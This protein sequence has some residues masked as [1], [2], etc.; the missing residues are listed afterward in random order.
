MTRFV[1]VTILTILTF[2]SVLKSTTIQ[3]PTDHPTIQAG[4][5]ASVD[6]DT[7]L[8]MP[9]TY[10]ENIDYSGH[11]VLVMSLMGSSV[12]TIEPAD[13][14]KST[15]KATN[16]EDLPAGL[17]GFTVR[18][19]G[20]ASTVYLQC[21]QFLVTENVFR[22]NIPG[23]VNPLTVIRGLGP[24]TITYNVFFNNQ[25]INTMF[26]S[27]TCQIINNTLDSNARGIYSTSFGTTIVNN[28]VTNCQEYTIIGAFA[29]LDFNDVWPAGTPTATGPHGFSA[30]PVY[31]DAGSHDYSLAFPSSCLG[32]G[33]LDPSYLDSLGRPRNLG[34]R[35]YQDTVVPPFAVRLN[36]GMIGFPHTIA[37]PPTISWGFYHYGY[38]QT[39]YELEV[40]T[41]SDWSVAEL[42]A[43]GPV[44]SGDTAIL[45][46]GADLSFGQTYYYRVR[47]QDASGWGPWVERVSVVNTPPPTPA[48]LFPLS[49]SP[50]NARGAIMA[51]QNVTDID[52]DSVTYEFAV[53]ED[54]LLSTLAAV[55]VEVPPDSPFTM[56]PPCSTLAFDRTYWWV[57]RAFDGYDTSIATAP[58]L[59]QTHS[60]PIKI[61]IPGAYQTIQ[62]AILNSA[63]EDTIELAPG[64]Y[65]EALY[66]DNK[67][68]V[69]RSSDGREVT[70]IQPA[71]SNRTAISV[72]GGSDGLPLI[73]GFTLLPLATG[74][75]ISGTGEATVEDCDIS[76]GNR[77][78]G[79]G[80]YFPSSGL[81][82]RNCD[83]HDNYASD[84]GGAIYIEGG[85]IENC[86]IY[87]NSA[88]RGPGIC[89]GGPITVKHNL[90]YGNSGAL[91]EGSAIYA[92]WDHNTTH[93][94]ITNNTIALNTRGITAN[95]LHA[96]DIS[97]NIIA[98]NDFAGVATHSGSATDC[99]KYNDLYNNG[100]GDTCL[101]W[102]GFSAD[103]QF[104]DTAARDFTL[105]QNSPCIDAGYVDS[106]ETDP[107]GTPPDLGAIPYEFGQPTATNLN[108]GSDFIDRV[109]SPNP[110]FYWSILD[111]LHRQQTS[112]EVEVGTSPSIEPF[113]VW[114]SGAVSTADTSL[115][116]GATGVAE[117]LQAGL[118]YY[119]RIRVDVGTGF[120]PWH[121]RV[122]RTNIPPGVPQPIRPTGITCV[123]LVELELICDTA[124]NPDRD[125]IWYEFQVFED[126]TA[127]SPLAS[128]TATY[129]SVTQNVHVAAPASLE[130][131][132]QY[133]WRVRA[134]D[135]FEYSMW[136]P[137]ES[138]CTR[139]SYIRLAVPVTYPTIQGAINASSPGDTILISPGMYGGVG[140]RD[141][142]FTY[143]KDIT[144]IG[145]G[146][147]HET[148][149][150]ALG[151]L[152]DRHGIIRADTVSAVNL[153]FKGITFANGTDS[154]G[155][156]V[157]SLAN[158]TFD[159]CV[160]RNNH[161]FEG[162]AIHARD[163]NLT[164][165]SFTNNTADS[166]GAALF[167]TR[168]CTATNCRFEGNTAQYG[169]VIA[170]GGT[171]V[172]DS[173]L[174]DR[175]SAPCGSV[176]SGYSFN[177]TF[178]NCLIVNGVGIVSQLNSSII[179]F[180][181]CTVVNNSTIVCYVDYDGSANFRYSIVAFNA[182]AATAC[183]NGEIDSPFQ[184][185][186]YADHSC[187]YGNQSDFHGCLSGQADRN[188]NLSEDPMFCNQ[189]DDF[190][191]QEDSPCA[192]ASWNGGPIG[193]GS[194]GCQTI[195]V[196]DNPPPVVY[197]FNLTQNYPNP[198]NPTTVISYSIAQR[199]DV[200]LTIHNILGQVV[201]ELINQRQPA[202]NYSVTW[203][204]TDHSGRQ[205]AS[206]IYFYRLT[207]GNFV[208]SKKMV[209]L[210]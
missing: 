42:W 22:D 14:D 88:P 124:S 152:N 93:L 133:F 169:G 159:G 23:V 105:R 38:T 15:I 41:D 4:I 57:C 30:D 178:N 165:C 145:I 164:S 32:A 94:Y 191:L 151:G 172:F 187:V 64:V 89:A 174:F 63:P 109:V 177:A 158:V 166:G 179:N 78:R 132:K 21:N 147:S 198:F 161:G 47:L 85:V 76:G 84:R 127:A 153:V 31:R 69:L 54:S 119:S 101:N 112:C 176:I 209:L 34:A 137:W 141:L 58:M 92:I 27:D 79:G 102:F 186:A 36:D 19:G 139:G 199:S 197:T 185:T 72:S 188:S 73:Q 210:K 168:S 83:L 12:T 120:S 20:L 167:V 184:T 106:S 107:D 171:V 202:G 1:F 90:I 136:S 18:N 50:V 170:R 37:E 82:V 75:G 67:P 44:T 126:T 208:A 59:I 49:E 110:T 39:G 121:Y 193:Y 205:V 156:A 175:N 87:N 8:V 24:C 17:Q 118:L 55:S 11:S 98:F 51:V 160:F 155:G 52:G 114:R 43:P 142:D 113:D 183:S 53:Y 91:S 150:D 77:S 5:L 182:G 130:V 123:S 97:N 190:R 138:F 48:V 33:S 40:G 66:L 70:T 148:I 115:T 62:P 16:G 61:D 45:Y 100:D 206:G 28:I 95:R 71:D 157:Y 46:G 26:V 194:V 104:S 140:N 134:Y 189:S 60:L 99:I 3:V 6:G 65:R 111:S 154:L 80:I 29:E 2:S 204:G 196:E 86:V 13:P 162:G 68:I 144:V 96:S 143:K 117:A 192:T 201:D 125:S 195:D 173:C 74:S 81:T 9:G 103:P 180:N 7:V 108:F 149:I 200:H 116:F 129:D 207:A 131:D 25:G 135:T 10:V 181:Y 146:G 56:S 163:V 35:N 128:L 122:F 203:S